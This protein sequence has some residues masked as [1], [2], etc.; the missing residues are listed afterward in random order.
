MSFKVYILVTRLIYSKYIDLERELIIVLML[1][2]VSTDNCVF[3][4][5][6]SHILNIIGTGLQFGFV[7]LLFLVHL[8][9]LNVQPD[10]I[11]GGM[12]ISVTPFFTK[13]NQALAE[14]ASR[15]G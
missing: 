1:D 6:D 14:L 11:L 5:Q 8:C 2:V 4:S 15:V 7:T 3:K 13:R 10:L 9:I 12:Y